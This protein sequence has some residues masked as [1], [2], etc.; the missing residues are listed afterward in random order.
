[1]PT[2]GFG[3]WGGGILCNISYTKAPY[4][5]LKHRRLIPV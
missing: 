3:G 4:T 2:F 1:M 5:V